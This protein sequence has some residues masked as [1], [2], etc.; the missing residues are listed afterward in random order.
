MNVGAEYTD[1]LAYERVEVLVDLTDESRDL[2]NQRTEVFDGSGNLLSSELKTMRGF[3]APT[4]DI[5][6]HCTL[7]ESTTPG[8]FHLYIDKAMAWSDYVKLLTTL[9]DVGIIQPGYCDLS[10]ARGASYLRKPGIV[11]TEKDAP[12]S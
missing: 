7:I 5:D 12:D 4:L 2:I 1:S 9:R 6:M 8:H 3:H 10:L 11:K